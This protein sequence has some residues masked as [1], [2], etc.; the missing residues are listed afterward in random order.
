MRRTE[1]RI[2]RAVIVLATVL[3]ALAA[4]SASGAMPRAARA[5]PPTAHP[6]G[7]SYSEWAARWWEWA[8]TQPASASPLVDETGASCE[9]GQAGRVWFLAGSLTSSPV[10]RECTVPNGTMLFV[11]IV[12]YV[13]CAFD[14]DP[15][16]QQTSEYV[17]E[18]VAFVRDA[19]S[20]LALTV[21]GRPVR[22]LATRYFET[23]TIFRVVLPEDNLF[24]LPAGMI[25]APCADAGY[26]VMLPPLP[27]GVHMVRFAG[28]LGDFA[29]NVRYELVVSR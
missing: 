22:D 27:P 20:G 3:V 12:N 24:G 4:G 5:I 18:Q 23:S 17:R 7:H 6:H 2:A 8:L 25:L 19:A 29:E 14:S 15:P 21:D 1:L 26:Y 16:E 9:R 28:M 13:Y 11:P 10:T